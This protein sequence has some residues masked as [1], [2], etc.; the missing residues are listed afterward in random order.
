MWEKGRQS[1]EHFFEQQAPFGVYKKKN[2]TTPLQR[3]YNAVRQQGLNGVVCPA[4]VY[5]Y[6]NF[7]KLG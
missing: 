3:R 6:L 4:C 1:R 5:W 7:R 2:C